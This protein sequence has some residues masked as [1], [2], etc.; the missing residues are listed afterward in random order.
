M[1]SAQPNDAGRACGAMLDAG[2]L[3]E[4]AG[5]FSRGCPAGKF[6]H[7]ADRVAMAAISAVAEHAL[8]RNVSSLASDCSP[9]ARAALLPWPITAGEF[10]GSRGT[11]R[12]WLKGDLLGI[13]R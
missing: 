8:D 12:H 4:L 11:R 13:R 10:A 5:G 6:Q 9:S 3:A 7:R 1:L 2:R